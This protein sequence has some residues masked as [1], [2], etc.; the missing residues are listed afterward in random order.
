MAAFLSMLMLVV[1]WLAI[2]AGVIAFLLLGV[3]L[4]GSL[5]GGTM[6]VPGMEAYVE[7]VA[8][9]QFIAGLAGLAVFA[10]GI[11]YVCIQLRSILSTLASGDP[12]HHG[13]GSV[14]AGMVYPDEM[15]CHPHPSSLSLA[16][17][18]MGWALQDCVAISL[19][20]RAQRVE[21]RPALGRTAH[22]P[23]GRADPDARSGG[24]RRHGLDK[25][26]RG[27]RSD[28]GVANGSI[29]HCIGLLACGPAWPVYCQS[30]SRPAGSGPN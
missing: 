15:T 12:F 27:H 8:P 21:D 3:G 20:G 24:D 6:R 19:H 11:I 28:K 16:A 5:N 23:C 22:G 18:R 17:A 13:V 25:C 26:G 29:F 10:P 14:L 7:G 4:I 1:I 30:I 2:I 9:G